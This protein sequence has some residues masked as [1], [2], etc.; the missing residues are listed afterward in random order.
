MK[1]D[2][3]SAL[4][5]LMGAAALTAALGLVGFFIVSLGRTFPDSLPRG[6][7]VASSLAKQLASD[8]VKTGLRAEVV[9][10]AVDGGTIVL[11]APYRTP[12]EAKRDLG[13]GTYQAESFA[14]SSSARESVMVVLLDRNR[15][16]REC[17][18]V[19]AYAFVGGGIVQAQ[20]GQRIEVALDEDG[21]RRSIRVLPDLPAS[22][23]AGGRVKT[24]RELDLEVIENSVK[25]G[26]LADQARP[27][28]HF[29]Y[30]PGQ[31]GADKFAE[32][33]KGAGFQIDEV[34]AREGVKWVVR[35]SK[36]GPLEIE[37]IVAQR[38]A[39]KDA[40]AKFGGEYDGWE[41]A[42]VRKSK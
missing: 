25:H 3:Q 14:D 16:I 33:A 38:V 5:W 11:A 26:D 8:D 6:G 27:I 22:E 31:S 10:P 12:E 2:R 7:G 17:D 32:W 18:W 41:T 28:E 20:E 15:Q 42:L 19:E 36:V 37:E 4:V 13:L 1:L 34:A 35:F 29:A 39:A 23:P 40:S 9:V 24:E 30:F 21:R